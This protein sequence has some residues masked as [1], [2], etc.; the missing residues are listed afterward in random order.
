MRIWGSFKSRVLAAKTFTKEITVS[1]IQ[2]SMC[3]E[4]SGGEDCRFF[5]SPIFRASHIHFLLSRS[6]HHHVP[7][8]IQARKSDFLVLTCARVADGVFLHKE[9]AHAGKCRVCTT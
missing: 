8:S 6:P 9:D 1:S 3:Y 2:P 4:I 7:I 5:S